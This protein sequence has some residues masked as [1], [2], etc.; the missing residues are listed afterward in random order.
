MDVAEDQQIQFDH[1]HPFA[2]D[3]VS[4]LENIAPMSAECNRQ[5]ST[6]SL[7]DRAQPFYREPSLS[8]RFITTVM[9]W[10]LR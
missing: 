3:G 6:L 5:K 1:I 2:K 10:L 8:C 9:D 7:D 4:E